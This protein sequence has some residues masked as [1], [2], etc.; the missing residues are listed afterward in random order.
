MTTTYAAVQ[1]AISQAQP[2]A[3]H[4]GTNLPPHSKSAFAIT[5][6]CDFSA[7]GIPS[8]G[9]AIDTTQFANKLQMKTIQTVYIDNSENNGYVS[10]YNPLFDQT[11]ALP[12]GY[13]GYFPILAPLISGSK[14]Y[15]TSTG[16]QLANIIFLNSLM[17]LA[18]WAATVTPP[19]TGNP[20]AVSDAILDATVSNNRVNA[21]TI[22]AQATA[23]DF[24]GTIA[25]GGTPQLILPAN[26]S[27]R[28]F[29]LQN[30]DSVNNESL[31]FGY[32]NGIAVA[33]PGSYG[34]GTASGA[35]YPGGSYQGNISN[36]IYAVAATTG[37]K[38]SGFWW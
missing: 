19:S 38:F 25:T 6:A 24:S 10:V 14:F 35:A 27:R 4:G 8:T 13:Q 18:S 5:A 2:V 30:I 33:S 21:S 26:A 34:L 1:A 36:A 37:H 28:G 17:P 12:A 32:S 22:Q 20:L 9:Y 11:F 29:F 23:T 31:W 3:F 15:V 7:S 16:D